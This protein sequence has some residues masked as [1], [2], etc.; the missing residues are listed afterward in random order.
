VLNNPVIVGSDSGSVV[1]IVNSTFTNINLRRVS[2]LYD[3]WSTTFNINNVTFRYIYIYVFILYFFFF[4][5][6]YDFKHRIW[7]WCYLCD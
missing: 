3:Y 5:C 2:L 7:L 6:Q 4:F 1:N